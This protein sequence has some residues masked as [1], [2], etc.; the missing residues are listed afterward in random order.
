MRITTKMLH[1]LNTL[2]GKK[3]EFKAIRGKTV[4]MYNC[5]PTVY[6]YAHIG[7]L[8]A[9]LSADILRRTLEYEGFLVNQV[10]NITDVGHL[11]SDAD[12][13]K[14][15]IE[16]TAKKEKKTAEEIVNFY[17]LAFFDDLKK[18]N[19]RTD[20]TRFPKATEHIAQ[21]INLIKKLEKK[22]F[23]YKTSGGIYFDTSKFKG[24]GKLGKIQ[25]KTL[26]EGSRVAA[27]PKKRNPTDFALWK[28]SPPS[29]RVKEKR[30]QEW[31]S[32][33]RKGFPGWHIECSAMSIEYLG[34]TFDIHT[35]GMDHIPIHHNNE[36]AQSEAATGK[37]FVR[38][39]L[40]NAFVNI[41]GE[42]MSKSGKNFVRLQTIIDKGFSPLAYRYWILKAHYRRPMKYSSLA[43]E[44][45]DRTLKKL[46]SKYME[47]PRES[48][49]TDAVYKEKF[50]NFINDDLD[51][52]GALTVL[53]KL[54]D[55]SSIKNSDK[56][57]TILDFDQVLGLGFEKLQMPEIPA[58]IIGLVEKRESARK[59]KDWKTAD[60]IRLEIKSRGYG[61][62][63]EDSGPK[64]LPEL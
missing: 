42:R 16:E 7:N 53:W 5:G 59:N 13:G 34:K 50:K 43:I 24:Y 64:I 11:T 46:W 4:G 26:K 55:D 3:E 57:A 45:A 10:I 19:I 32:P 47:L 48:G 28:F 1:L 20:N 27:N 29:T 30:Q 31:D 40:H 37:L 54:M 62:T 15:K 44:D 2:S 60:K 39:W 41:K 12:T 61:V 18:L 52:A 58:E 6:N 33:W 25:L 35:G 17:T 22:G 38:Y 14:D 21:Q 49:S 51:T 63:D 23:A 56:R 9:F 8:R 36:I